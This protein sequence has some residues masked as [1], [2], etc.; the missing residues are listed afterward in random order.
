MYKETLPSSIKATQKNAVQNTLKIIFDVS[1]VVSAGA[2]EPFGRSG[3][4]LSV[5]RLSTNAT[6]KAM[7]IPIK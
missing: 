6:G 5:T 4:K 2:T 7:N 3:N 1:R